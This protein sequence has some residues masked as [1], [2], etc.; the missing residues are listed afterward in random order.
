MKK[1]KEITGFDNLCVYNNSII[2]KNKK[3][4][5]QVD[6]NMNLVPL[7]EGDIYRA[8][9]LGDDLFYQIENAYNT[10]IYKKN[11]ALKDNFRY[12]LRT[13]LKCTLYIYIYMEKKIMMLYF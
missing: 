7:V 11:V 5:Q 10:Y 8:I 3:S 1:I 13:A 9:I 12:G 4:I 2:V 6:N